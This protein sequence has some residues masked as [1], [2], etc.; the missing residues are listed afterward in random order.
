MTPTDHFPGFDTRR[1][2]TAETEIHLRIG[3]AG[4]PLLCLYGF[5]ETHAMWHR[6]APALARHFTVVA[7]DLRGYGA[8]AVPPQDA[9]LSAYSKSAMGRD[10][11]EVMAAIGFDRFA[12]LAHDRG[13]R[14]AYR[15]MLEH[16]ATVSRAVLLDIVPT[17]DVWQSFAD[18]AAALVMSH[19]TFLAQATPLPETLIGAAPDHWL[20]SRFVRAGAALPAWL[21]RDVYADYRRVHGDPERR[22]VHCNDYRAGATVDLEADL[23][24]RAAGQTIAAPLLVLWGSRGNLAPHADP[25]AAWRRWCPGVGGGPVASGHYIPEEAPDALLDA[26]LPFLLGG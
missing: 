1:I 26:A 8:S 15:L 19:W 21:D 2:A 9:P 22:R 18:P 6:S 23:A 12:I 4:P 24:S 14:A 16:P 3:G 5:P 25:L 11:A 10:M 7:A 13:A 17:L 20:E